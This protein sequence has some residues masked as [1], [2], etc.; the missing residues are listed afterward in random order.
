MQKFGRQVIGTQNIDNCSRYCQSPAT[1]G[2]FRIVG[3][4]GDSGSFEDLVYS[5][6]IVIVGANSAEAHPVLVARMKRAQ[7][8]FDAK[9]IL[10]DPRENKLARRA[11]LHFRPRPGTDLVWLSAM[12]RYMFDHGYAKLD[13]LNQWVNNI[14]EY[15][16]S[17]E[18]YTMEY[19]S[20]VCEIPLETLEKLAQELAASETIAIPFQKNPEFGK[21]TEVPEHN[22]F[23]VSGV[24]PCATVRIFPAGEIHRS[25]PLRC[26]GDAYFIA[27]C[28]GL[29]LTMIRPLP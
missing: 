15:K 1:T 26:P 27:P 17:L 9:L 22:P 29:P 6:A 7:K 8:L 12:S 5:K 19:A 2:L 24:H 4:G 25:G 14:E 21:D 28:P 3:H 18:P 11:D 20:K 16:K 13:F 10:A 23:V